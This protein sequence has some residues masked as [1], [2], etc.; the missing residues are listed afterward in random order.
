MLQQVEQAARRTA[1]GIRAPEDH[2]PEPRVD[3]R[4][5]AHRARF[6]GHVEIAFV[7]SPVLQ[8]A[9]SLGNR[10]HFRMGGGVL[11][12]L[13]LVVRPADDSLLPVDDDG[14][15]RHFPGG[16]GSSGL[17][18]GFLHEP[19]VALEVDDRIF[20]GHAREIK[21]DSRPDYAT[22]SAPFHFYQHT[23]MNI[24]D[25]I[26]KEQFRSDIPAFKVGDA[27]KVHVRVV[28]GDKERIQVFQGIVICRNGGGL[29]E[30]FTVRRISY[31]EGVERVFPLH[32]P[33]LAKIEV[34]KEGKARRAKLSYLR[35]RKGKQAV[36]VRE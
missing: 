8:H 20:F 1:L 3:D 27:V 5:R 21:V 18:Q 32:S 24:I 30:S 9:L 10:E 16:I 14:A 22:Y 34:A 6:L 29:S 15:D 26:E 17:T 13:D 2:P 23:A 7:Q 19:L 25:T 4:S 12:G 33:R 28:E 11:E 31:G 35:G 36:A